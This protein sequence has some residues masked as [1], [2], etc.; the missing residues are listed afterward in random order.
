MLISSFAFADTTTLTLDR[1]LTL[2]EVYALTIANDIT[3]K[4]ADDNIEIAE[5]ALH[6]ALREKEDL[7]WSYSTA[8]AY[9]ALVYIDDYYPITTANHLENVKD[10]KQTLLEDIK[11]NV[12]N[13]YI[14]YK[15]RQD[16][17]TET[18]ASLL[19]AQTTYNNKA[20][21]YELGLITESDLKSYEISLMQA[22][23]SVSKAEND[24]EQATI[25]FNQMIGYPI[26]TTFTLST[27]I[28]VATELNYN[29]IELTNNIETYDAALLDIKQDIDEAKLK[30]ELIEEN[31]LDRKSVT[32]NGVTSYQY[33]EKQGYTLAK[34][35]LEDLQEDYAETL[36]DQIISLR[37]TY[38]NLKSEDLTVKI[39]KLNY[40]SAARAFST[41]IV[42]HDLGLMTAF[43]LQSAKDTRDSAYEAYISSFNNLYI[44]DLSFS[45]LIGTY[46]LDQVQ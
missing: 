5:D 38:N 16:T 1:N 17:L 35:A 12:T 4:Q 45:Q 19:K 2:D 18:K 42:K 11:I 41:A 15:Q 9:M 44:S 31:V 22:D 36:K 37:I 46:Q 26:D 28:D 43:D 24:L 7:E 21:E 34:N 13:T 30:I 40:E 14:S 8:D 23:L 32:V 20:K 29:I 3:V 39:N 27:V 6:D 10:D 25:S 33:G